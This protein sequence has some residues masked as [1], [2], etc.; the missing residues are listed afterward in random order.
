MSNKE[1]LTAIHERKPVLNDARHYFQRES[2]PDTRGITLK[3]LEAVVG[4]RDDYSED[5]REAHD[6]RDAGINVSLT[7]CSAFEKDA[8]R[9]LVRPDAQFTIDTE[10]A[11]FLDLFRRLIQ[12]EPIKE[13]ELLEL[14]RL[15]DQNVRKIAPVRNAI[16]TLVQAANDC[17]EGRT[18]LDLEA[19]IAMAKDRASKEPSRSRKTMERN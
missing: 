5:L 1:A 13:T 14:Q 18:P 8:I 3:K 7:P 16:D 4:T 12:R 17:A 10:L 11:K 15:A 9:A 2:F 6:E 19:T